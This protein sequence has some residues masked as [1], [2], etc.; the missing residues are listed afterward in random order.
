M[1]T[2][3]SAY[4]FDELSGWTES[5][6]FYLDEIRTL[7]VRLGEV[8]QRNSIPA[9]AG[10]VETEQNKL[11][12]AADRFKNL[13]DQIVLQEEVLSSGDQLIEDSSIQP[14]TDKTQ[15]L[16]RDQMKESEKNYIDAKYAC[17]EFLS[18]T[19]KK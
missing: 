19:L 10:R 15:T 17:Y 8:I 12:H 13:H 5:I 2:T 7:G 18:A 4:Y 11:N 1:A 14:E 9:I 16:L 3:I 6:D